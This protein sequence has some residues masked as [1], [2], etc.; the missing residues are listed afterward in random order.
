MAEVAVSSAEAVLEN[1]RIGG[2][3]IRV[4]ILCT[5]VQI[6]DGYDVGS[7]GWA[8][9]PLTHAWNLPPPAFA[10][11]FMWSSIGVVVG[12]PFAG[13]IGDRI[14]RRP[15]LLGSVAVVGVTSL[16]NAFAGSIVTLSL[17]RFL[18]GIGLSGAFP[19]AATLA[20]E[21]AP[22]RLRATFIMATLTGAPFGGFVGGLLVSLL[23]SMGFGWPV[24]FIL[25]G[26]FPLV[27]L[28][29]V[30]LWLPES[31]RFLARKANLPARQAALL[32]RLGIARGQ[33]DP[34]LFDL[35]RENPVKML[36]S[37]GYAPQTALLWIIYFCSLMNLFLFVYW[38]PEVLHLIGLTPAQ[39][40]FATSPYPLGGVCAAF[41]LG[42]A[43]D[44]FGPERA[45]SL[46]YALGA[47][48]IALIALVAMPYALLLTVIF[49]AGLTIIGS[50]TGAVGTCGKLYPARMRTSGLA[51]AGGFGRIGSIVAPMLGGY[52]LSIGLPPTQIFLSACFIALVAAAATAL[53][54]L[55]GAP[56]AAI[57]PELAP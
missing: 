21:Y 44:R 28:P 32:D 35:A 24:I 51:W 56:A 43:I 6:C 31:P 12:A 18:T 55:R 29:I 7:I 19:S 34:Q 14:G 42:V 52:L 37:Q 25:G 5:L 20:G 48:F 10:L 54:V 36:F 9:P 27:L 13:P 30:G 4:A 38:L 41:Y 11:A 15:L 40:V 57:R 39:A 16:L 1:Q 8:V 45:L 17:W 46:H 23:L 22:R 49:F 26:A 50:Q 3:Q 47:G 33:T 2:L 53:L